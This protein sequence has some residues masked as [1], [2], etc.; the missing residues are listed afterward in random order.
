MLLECPTCLWD[1][2]NAGIKRP[3]GIFP[4]LPGGMD[5][6]L[7][8]YFDTYRVKKELPPEIEDLDAT[9]YPLT[10]EFEV[11][12]N[13]DFGRGGFKAAFPEWNMRLSG[14]IDD[15]LLVDAKLVPFDYKTRGFPLKDDTAGHYQK[16]L[17]MY[18]LLFEEN[19]LAPASHGYLLFFWPER[20]TPGRTVFNTELVQMEVSAERAR[21]TL[22]KVHGILEG[23]RPESEGC[24]YCTYRKA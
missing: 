10:P 17:D 14:A 3:R 7:K 8:D 12:R 18:A 11:W 15:I 13:I 23:G 24:E 22:A 1:H 19:D 16:Q 20:H 21:E 2:Y 4:S 6:I 5:L 9:L